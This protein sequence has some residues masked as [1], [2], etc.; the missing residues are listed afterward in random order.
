MSKLKTYITKLLEIAETR[1][2]PVLADYIKQ[3]KIKAGGSRKTS[4]RAYKQ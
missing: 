3:N 2:M 1:D 4:R